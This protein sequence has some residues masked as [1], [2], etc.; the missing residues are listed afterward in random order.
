MK[1]TPLILGSNDVVL[2]QYAMEELETIGLLKFDLLGLRNLSLIENI[3]KTI[4][5]QT[6]DEI[7]IHALPEK[8][9][10]TYELLRRGQT[11]GIFQLESTGMKRVLRQLKPAHFEDIIA[12]NALYRPGPMDFRS[13]EHT[14]ELQSRGHL[15]C[16]LLLEK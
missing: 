4:E 11:N 7:D 12:V 13:E 5:Y 10:K 16:R 9:E 3:V 1:H 15:V 8:D 2:T 6:K 14:S